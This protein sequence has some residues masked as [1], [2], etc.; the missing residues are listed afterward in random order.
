MEWSPAAIDAWMVLRGVEQQQPGFVSM[1]R[2]ALALMGDTLPSSAIRAALHDRNVWANPQ[3]AIQGRAHLDMNGFS[4]YDFPTEVERCA[5]KEKARRV[6][7]RHVA[8]AL[9]ASGQT[10]FNPFGLRIDNLVE[11]V[12]MLELGP[13]FQP[14]DIEGRWHGLIDT[15]I[16]I[17]YQDI[18]NIDWLAETSTKAVTIWISPVLL[19]ELDEMKFYSRRKRA[20]GRAEAFTRWVFPLLAKAVT[21]DGAPMPSRP[22]VVLRAWEP[23]LRQSVP[24][25][26]HL[27][28]ASALIDRQ[29][30]AKFI[31]GDTGQKL[32]A[33]AR[34]LE[35]FDLDKRWLLPPDIANDAD[36]N[37]A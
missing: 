34:G 33:L 12:R 24:D 17:Q 3:D 22:G 31:T 2:A 6:G 37:E 1:G 35:T 13:G 19:D 16:A 20:K 14:S 29:V 25:S 5:E 8:L 23:S 4:I 36:A 9:A 27:E 7:E 30:P 28:A 10:A 18:H 26:R 32:R 15:S 11:K 21:P